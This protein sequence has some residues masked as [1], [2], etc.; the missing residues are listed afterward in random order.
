MNSPHGPLKSIET[1][2]RWMQDWRRSSHSL[3]YVTWS[4]PQTGRSTGSQGCGHTH[5]ALPCLSIL[6]SSPILHCKRLQGLFSARQVYRA[7]VKQDIPQVTLGLVKFQLNW[8]FYVYLKTGVWLF[9]CNSV[10]YIFFNVI[11]SIR[12]RLK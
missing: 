10:Y 12:G 6:H 1:A 3:S 7:L 2:F 9:Y 11:I 8:L 4:V 5:V